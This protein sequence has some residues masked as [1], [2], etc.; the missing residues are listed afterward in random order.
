M[1]KKFLKKFFVSNITA[2]KLVALN[3]LNS[4]ENTFHRQSVL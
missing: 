3:C 4:E 2:Y 1:Q